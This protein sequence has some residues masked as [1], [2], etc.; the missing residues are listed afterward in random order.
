[1]E[2]KELVYTTAHR[3]LGGK[4]VLVGAGVGLTGDTDSALAQVERLSATGVDGIQVFPPRPGALR[5]RDREL[6]RYYDEVAGVARCPVIVGENV[7]LVGYEMGPA[8]LQRILDR[9]REFIGLSYTAPVGVGVLSELVGA[10]ADRV[11][12]RSGWLYH[13]ANMA[14]VGGAGV[15]CFD[16]NVVPRLCAAIWEAVSGRAGAS[17]AHALLGHLYR[18]N[19]VL[20][21]YGNPMSIK[22]T[23]A[24]LGLPAGHLRRPFLGLDTDETAELEAS[25]DRLRAEVDLDRWL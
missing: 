7:T 14:A 11:E 6:E 10:L 15:L 9:H 5:P 1:V 4:A 3:V 16:A 20:S 21:R 22:A 12:V 8:L 24:H 25:I 2:E 17:S 19:A 18:L 13:F 23:L